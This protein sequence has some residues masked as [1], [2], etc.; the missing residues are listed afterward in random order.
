MK[1]IHIIL[2]LFSLLPSNK[3]DILNPQDIQKEVIEGIFDGYDE[4]DGYS[5]LVID[6]ESETESVMYFSEVLEAVLKEFD[7]KST[8]LVGKKFE[9]TYEIEE[10][11]ELD[12]EEYGESYEKY[13]IVKLVK[14]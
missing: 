7:L 6:K 2:A 10:L 11:E 5:F 8:N 4:E 13:T 3:S 1:T 12:D 9:I 14:K